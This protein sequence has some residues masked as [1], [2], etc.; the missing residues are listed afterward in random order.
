M[1]SRGAFLVLEGIDRSGKSTQA[2][3]LVDKLLAKGYKAEYMR[4][5]ERTNTKTGPIIDSYLKSATEV[6]DQVIHLLFSA[7]RWE[8]VT[9]IKSKLASGITLV[10]DRYAYSGVSY[11]AAKPN[12]SLDWCKQP[13]KGLPRP[14][15]VIFLNIDINDATKR[16]EYGEERYEKVEFQ[17]NVK[18]IYERLFDSSYWSKVE[19]KGSVDIVSEKIFSLAEISVL[20][21]MKNPVELRTLWA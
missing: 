4:F 2:K 18:D 5:P 21:V 17:K 19:A 9:A 8:Y 7:N 6:N 11:T 12:M 1:V 14:D 16:G 15:K 3:L 20:D 10:V 13:D